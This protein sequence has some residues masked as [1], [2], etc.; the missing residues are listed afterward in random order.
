MPV[1]LSQT[2]HGVGEDFC[3]LTLPPLGIFWPP[4][5]GVSALSE[6]VLAAQFPLEWLCLW[7]LLP[8]TQTH[9]ILPCEEEGEKLKV[10]LYLQ[11]ALWQSS[12]EEH[13]LSDPISLTAPSSQ[14][15]QLHFSF[16][17]QQDESSKTKEG[18]SPSP[19]L[20]LNNYMFIQHF[21]FCTLSCANGWVIQI[22]ST[23]KHWRGW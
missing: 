4:L 15:F 17:L 8:Y 18:P 23:P 6:G 16:S 13:C 19:S 20:I 21:L 9:I 12:K 2:K 14:I 7:H 5:P 10:Y 3:K 22:N 11:E 1:W